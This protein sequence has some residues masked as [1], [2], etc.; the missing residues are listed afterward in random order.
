MHVKTTDDKW[1]TIEVITCGGKATRKYENFVN[2]KNGDKMFR[3]GDDVAT[4]NKQSWQIK[5]FNV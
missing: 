1:K 3:S 4:L 5:R 2:I